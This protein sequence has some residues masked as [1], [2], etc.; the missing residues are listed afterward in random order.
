MEFEVAIDSLQ[1]TDDG[2]MVRWSDATKSRFN[3]LWLRDNCPSGGDK[4]TAHRT[5]LTSDLDPDLAVEDASLND[6]G[7]VAIAFS[8][9]HS[10]TFPPTWLKANCPEVVTRRSKP[11]R[12]S[13]FTAGIRVP[14]MSLPEKGSAE[15]CDLLDG[16]A[17]WGAVIVNDVPTNETG[18]EALASLVGQ[19]RDSD[20]GRLF[21]IIVEPEAWESSQST[22]AQD[23]HTDDPYRYTPSGT[24]ILHCVEVSTTGGE[25]LLVDGFGI[26]AELEDDEPDMFDLLSEVKIP[27]VRHRNESVD[28][29]EDVHLIAYAPVIAL[30]RDNE[31]CGIRFH[32]RATGPFDI[33]P[34]IMGDYYRAFIEFGRRVNDP[35]KVLQFGAQPGQAILYDNQRVLH[36]RTAFTAEGGRRH[37]RLC[38]INRDQFHSRLRR[39]REDH[40][41]PGVDERLPA[42]NLS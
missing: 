35:S 13:N 2:M 25:S 12:M 41:R 27:F 10:S 6:D 14:E 22:L 40:Q 3:A 26:A 39:L 30:D 19:V 23:P 21:D 33:D 42:G 36:G 5:F 8:S 31:I 18:T 1:V 17:E 28:Q 32:Q 34:K 16:V 7:D 11:K 15:H 20:F 38:T 37:M 24:S 9:G 4:R 29:G